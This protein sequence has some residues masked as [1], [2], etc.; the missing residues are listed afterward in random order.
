MK[1]GRLFSGKMQTYYQIIPHLR[2]RM[3]E[4]EEESLYPG[5]DQQRYLFSTPRIEDLLCI[6]ALRFLYFATKCYYKRC[7]RRFTA[8]SFQK[9]NV[10]SAIFSR[11]VSISLR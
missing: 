10:P 2:L 3:Q 6:E 8:S 11:T 9:E 1:F 7:M 4:V 5:N